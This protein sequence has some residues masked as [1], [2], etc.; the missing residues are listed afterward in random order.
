MSSILLSYLFVSIISA[1]MN[2]PIF[3]NGD[4]PSMVPVNGVLSGTVTK[5]KELPQELYGT[6]SVSSAV[7]E[8][9]NPELYRKKGSDIWTLQRGQDIITL[10]NP[11]TGA[12][13][14]ITVDE[15]KGNNAIFTRVNNNDKF[16]EKERVNITVD[17]DRFYG[18]DTI[19]TEYYKKGKYL[20]TSVVKYDVIGNK[21][22]GPA[23]KRI[24]S[25]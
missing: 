13:A 25:E 9:N 3:L 19:E 10:S 20:Y 11:V 18:S 24:F 1:N 4:E 6:W 7:I 17:E 22:S 14:S 21:I 12:T 16:R 5:S 15:V 2:K 23:I 8:T